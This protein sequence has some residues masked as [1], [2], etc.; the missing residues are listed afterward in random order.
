MAD[1]GVTQS[2]HFLFEVL[3]WPSARL[4]RGGILPAT[5]GGSLS[6]DVEAVSL[7]LAL[8]NGFLDDE[9]VVRVNGN[10]VFRKQ[11]V[12]TRTQVGLADTIEVGIEHGRARIEISLPARD[13]AEALEIDVT[14]P[15][16][17]GVSVDPEDGI[18]YAI[19]YRPFRYM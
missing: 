4:D 3:N 12:K 19:Q 8:Q 10:E 11:G 18:R 15:T 17:I 16:Y 1:R 7:H 14:K 2:S 13:I 5:R 9:V 6:R